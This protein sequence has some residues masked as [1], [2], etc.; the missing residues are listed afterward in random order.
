MTNAELAAQL[1][2]QADQVAERRKILL[3]ASTAL[4]TTKTIRSAVRIVNDWVGPE[5]VKTAAIELIQALD[6]ART[7]RQPDG[8]PR[9]PRET[10]DTIVAT[11][12]PQLTRAVR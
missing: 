7:S 10:I 12:A 2:Q 11:H 5:P 4:A 6:P 8:D 3:C 9:P 1:R